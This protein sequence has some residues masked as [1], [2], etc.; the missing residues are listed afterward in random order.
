[1]AMHVEE[2]SPDLY[3]L[4]YFRW[5]RNEVLRASTCPAGLGNR[6]PT[7]SPLLPALV[8]LIP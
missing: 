6:V 8:M 7:L 5:E 1:M 4:Y 2:K 3:A